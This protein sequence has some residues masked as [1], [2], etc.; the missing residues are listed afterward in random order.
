MKKRLYKY[1]AVD[2]HGEPVDGSMEETSADRVTRIL[3]ER[4]IQVN[5]VE[6]LVPERVPTDK[7]RRLSW[8]DISVFNEQLLAITKSKLPLAPSIRAISRDLKK[9]SLKTALNGLHEDLELGKSLE[10]A[11]RNRLDRFPP[12]YV[13]MIQ[14]GEKTGNLSG[15]LEIMNAHSTRMMDLKSKLRMVFAYPLMVLT[16]SAFVI[17]FILVSVVPVFAEIFGDF[18][19]TLPGPTQLLVDLS[20][21]AINNQAQV[22]TVLIGVLLTGL[23]IR[24]V[25]MSTA[26]G[27]LIFD[28]LLLFTPLLGRVFRI[29]SLARFSRSMGLMLNSRVPVL[30]SL[31]LA[32]SASGNSV[33]RKHANAAAIQ[34]AKG[35]KLADA[36]SDT[37]Y[38][39]HG[40]CWFLANGE[41]YGTLP[42]VLLDVSQ[43]YEKDVALIDG[44]LLNLLSPA[45]VIL[46]GFIV[47]FIVLALYMPIFSL[48]DAIQG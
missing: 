23:L 43:S 24:Y 12:M 35:E 5:S 45:I 1:R 28:R 2:S 26:K 7:G 41:S 21:L 10:E 20:N 27:Q 8:D 38:F 17:A 47:S 4:G 48:G 15:V 11:L 18:G 37:G 31:D 6:L 25:L 29:G 3:S 36:L 33:L 13:R 40:F 46:L 22:F 32:A 19:A 14:A 42:E 34:I 44:S 30:E 39:P 9:G 16:V